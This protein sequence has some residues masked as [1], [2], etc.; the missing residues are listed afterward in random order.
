MAEKIKGF[1]TEDGTL[2]SSLEAAKKHEKERENSEA[3]LKEIFLKEMS[4]VPKYGKY[5]NASN[6][7]FR[8]NVGNA[9]AL[10]ILKDLI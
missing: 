8:R 7:S 9:G 1:K 3:F 4:G 10:D 6:S 2:F 5:V